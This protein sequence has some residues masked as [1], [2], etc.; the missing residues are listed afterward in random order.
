MRQ[1]V[2]N[3][4]PCPAKIYHIFF[5][6]GMEVLAEIRFIDIGFFGYLRHGQLPISQSINDHQ[7]FWVPESFAGVRMQ[8][9]ISD[10]FLH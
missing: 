9:I 8:F 5:L 6:H 7:A 2:E 10:G 3:V 1:A 4:R